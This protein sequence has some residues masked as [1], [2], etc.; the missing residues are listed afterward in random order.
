MIHKLTYWEDMMNTF[1]FEGNEG[2]LLFLWIV[3]A[4]IAL[5]LWLSYRSNKVRLL[6]GALASI[7]FL[8]LG[9]SLT[10]TSLILEN[11][12]LITLCIIVIG[13]AVAIIAFLSVFSGILLLWNAFIVWKRERHSLANSLTLLVGLY[14]ILS[15]FIFWLLRKILPA[16]IAT[17]LSLFNGTISAYLLFWLVNFV[18][19]FFIYIIFRPRSN[20]R[21]MIVLGAGLL[22]GDQLSPLLKSR[23]DAALRFANKQKQKNNPLPL[24]IM[25]GGQGDNEKIPEGKAMADYALEM[26]YSPNLIRVENKSKTTYQNMLFSKEIVEK[27]NIPLKMGIF[28][29]SDYHVFRAA[30]YARLVGL[31]IDGIGAKTRRYF[32]FNALIREYIALLANHKLFH[33]VTISVLLIIDVVTIWGSF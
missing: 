2:I 1:Q 25:S 5:T 16:K 10:A 12:L 11:H 21:Y 15:P 18:M 32:V 20:Q 19:S 29:T 31:N 4:A 30:G 24:L 7:L 22:S 17:G 14:I 26:G 3:S 8:S 28:V 9:A 13:I 33:F 27:N 23:I 6:N